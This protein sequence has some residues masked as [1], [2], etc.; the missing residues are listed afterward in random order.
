VHPQGNQ[1]LLLERMENIEGVNVSTAPG[2]GH[3][4]RIPIAH[5]VERG[6]VT[7]FL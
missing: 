2:S 6:L 7:R 5:N 4:V 3:R 1:V